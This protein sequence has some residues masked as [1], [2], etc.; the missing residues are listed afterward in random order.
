ML[1]AKI[2]AMSVYKI[3]RR[4]QTKSI[5]R[6]TNERL[7]S[8]WTGCSDNGLVG[9]GSRFTCVGLLV[10]WFGGLVAGLTSPVTFTFLLNEDM[11]DPTLT[12]EIV[13]SLER[14]YKEHG[15]QALSL[16]SS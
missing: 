11:Q 7:T 2:R 6:E 4:S 8:E 14:S 10:C 13:P 15:D 1:L 16:L 3:T 9:T 5:T 12:I